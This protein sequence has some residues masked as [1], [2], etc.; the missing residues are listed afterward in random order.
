[1]DPNANLARQRELAAQ[2]LAHGRAFTADQSE[3]LA[4]L[5]QSLDEWII[6]GGFLPEAWRVVRDYPR[7]SP[8]RMADLLADDPGGLRVA[9]HAPVETPKEKR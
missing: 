7:I 1:M 8:Q 2:I 3:E 5:V 9:Q 4:A 6:N